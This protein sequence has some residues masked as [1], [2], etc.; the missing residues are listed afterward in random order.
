MD[1]ISTGNPELDQI[2]GFVSFVLTSLLGIMSALGSVLPQAW[3]IT[4]WLRRYAPDLRG[5]TQ[6]DPG[7]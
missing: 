5:S 4:Q 6:S 3:P 7:E 2:L 1:I